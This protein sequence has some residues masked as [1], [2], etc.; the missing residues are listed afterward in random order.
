MLVV[1]QLINDGWSYE[2]TV[3]DHDLALQYYKNAYGNLLVINS[4]INTNNITATSVP[5]VCP[6][7]VRSV[8]DYL[9]HRICSIQ[10]Q[11]NYPREAIIQ[12]KKH[13]DTFKQHTKAPEYAFEHAAWLSQQYLLFADLFDQAVTSG[14][15]KASKN[16][17]PG[18]YYYEAAM[19]MM[20]RR[21]NRT[22]FTNDDIRSKQMPVTK[23]LLSSINTSNFNLFLRQ[24]GWTCPE[25]LE[26]NTQSMEQNEL[27]SIDYSGI[28]IKSLYK[29]AEGFQE[30]GRPRMKSFINIL[31]A[32]EYKECSQKQKASII[33]GDFLK[34][35]EDQKWLP[36]ANYIQDKMSNTI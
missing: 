19:Q 29:A 25:L 8:G 16:Q 7:E 12:F 9:N 35:Y 23:D 26:T 15:V 11:L 36:L 13:T 2:S 32:D 4:K 10:F 18:Q 24:C 17:Q 31:I 1:A 28:I 27:D 22:E 33:Y 30:W 20:I 21:Q 3:K 14:V 6:Y 5:G 34:Y